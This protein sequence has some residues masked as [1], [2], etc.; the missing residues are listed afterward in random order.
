KNLLSCLIVLPILFT[1]SLSAQNL[2]PNYS[3]E[4][5]SSCP[6]ATNQVYLLDDWYDPLPSSPDYLNSCYIGSPPG[7]VGVPLNFMGYQEALT[8]EG[9]IGILVVGGGFREYVQAELTEPLV[10]GQCY[11]LEMFIS[12]GFTNNNVCNA[13]SHFGMYLSPSPPPA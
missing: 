6:T 3:F 8:G 2:V 5:Y 13:I 10:S 1:F 7:N 11:Y 4:N 12:P 9:Y